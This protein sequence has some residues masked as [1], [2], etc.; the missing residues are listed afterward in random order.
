MKNSQKSYFFN[1]SEKYDMKINLISNY[2]PNIHW[3]QKLEIFPQLNRTDCSRFGHCSRFVHLWV[4]HILLHGRD[5]CQSFTFGPKIFK[6]T[7]NKY[8]Q[9]ILNKKMTCESVSQIFQKVNIFRAISK[10]Y[11]KKNNM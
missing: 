5:S 1:H 8:A 10:I 11:K 2:S 4:A 9:S 7:N 6:I 3:V